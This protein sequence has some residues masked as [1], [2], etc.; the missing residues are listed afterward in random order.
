MGYYIDL[1]N[2]DWEI[3]ETAEV[4]EAL[5][6]MPTKYH[7]IK[8]GGSSNGE[9]W[10]S[11]MNDED[12]LN[13]KTAEEIFSQLGFETYHKESDTTSF[14][15]ESYSSK[16]GQEDLFLAVVAPFCKDGSY[17]EFRGE[18]GAEWQ[19][20]VRGGIMH[21]AEVMKKFDDP[22]PWRYSHFQFDDG[23]TQSF[24]IDITKP[25]PEGVHNGHDKYIKATV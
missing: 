21:Y 16:T 10:F 3:P 8:R 18:D 13:A 6:E 19:Y 23:K 7:A 22:H 5:K 2:A 9:S 25:L 4:L 20:S 11:W 24:A 1:T 15:L 12:I 14:S 17:I